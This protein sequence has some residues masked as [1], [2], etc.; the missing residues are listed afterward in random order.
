MSYQSGK[1]LRGGRLLKFYFIIESDLLCAKIV[2]NNKYYSSEILVTFLY[3]SHPVYEGYNLRMK[4][5]VDSVAK[6][7]FLLLTL[8]VGTLYIN[9]ISLNFKA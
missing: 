8:T 4:V 3:S 9:N 1:F 2:Y 7:N 5:V 6:I